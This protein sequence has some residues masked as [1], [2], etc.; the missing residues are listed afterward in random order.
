MRRLAYI[1]ALLF[2]ASIANSAT[3]YL[4]EDGTN[5]DSDCSGSSACC[6]G[7]MDVSDFN[8]G[9]FSSGDI[10]L[11][12][13]DGGTVTTALT[14]G[15]G[16]HDGVILRVADGDTFT[17]DVSGEAIQISADDVTIDGV[18]TTMP[19]STPRFNIKSTSRAIDVEGDNFT[20]QYLYL[21]IDADGAGYEA[22]DIAAVSN[23]TFSFCYIKD[24]A[25]YSGEDNTS[26]N[27][28]SSPVAASGLTIKGNRVVDF[29][30]TGISSHVSTTGTILVYWND[31]SAPNRAYGRPIG[32]KSSGA[33]VYVFE[34]YFHEYRTGWHVDNCD[35]SAGNVWVYNNISVN[36]YACCDSNYTSGT[37]SGMELYDD[38]G[39]S[40]DGRAY[41]SYNVGYASAS[42]Y[43]TV[44]NV[45]WYHN[46][47]KNIA[48]GFYS[49][50]NDSGN[51]VAID[52]YHLS[53]NVADDIYQEPQQ[54]ASGQPWEDM[55]IYIRNITSTYEWELTAQNNVT[56]DPPHAT[57]DVFFDPK[58]GEPDEYVLPTSA[59]D[60]DEPPT[61]NWNY[62][63]VADWTAS[64]IDDNYK[65]TLSLDIHG[66]PSSDS[67]VV[68]YG[69][70]GLSV[71]GSPEINGTTHG[72]NLGIK[73]GCLTYT[74]FTLEIESCMVVRDASPD[75]GAFEYQESALPITI[76]G[77]I[78]E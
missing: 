14:F 40:C 39:G 76:Q 19:Y 18:D 35:D 63:D 62:G 44:D 67:P 48:E 33:S 34:N 41:A 36:N 1:I 12:C 27:G 57:I 11:G 53:N 7:A 60:N 23:T 46:T 2:F 49:G 20:A 47:Y 6:V 77:L 13:D 74:Q 68:D 17:I 29:G 30:H 52:N 9:S 32:I 51:A 24:A 25:P 22:V 21:E 50:S 15:S 54:Q 69:Q 43:Q 8:S 10:V 72:I 3:Y 42:C 61:D 70:T 58:S 78:L 16:T 31:V 64:S 59:N 65:T 4:R 45:R 55:V 71:T 26:R 73:V 75:V 66:E 38:Y 28:I 37:C 56:E 5:A